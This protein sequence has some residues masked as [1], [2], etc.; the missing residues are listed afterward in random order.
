[1]LSRSFSSASSTDKASVESSGFGYSRIFSRELMAIFT[2]S[3]RAISSRR[4][5]QPAFF[6]SVFDISRLSGYKQVIRSYAR[7][8]VAVMGDYLVCCDMLPSLKEKLKSA[9]RVS[10]SFPIRA[11][12][13]FAVASSR[14]LCGPYPAG[15]CFRDMRIEAISDVPLGPRHASNISLELKYYSIKPQ[16]YV[17]V[18]A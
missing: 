17:R 15:L 13:E 10:D 5:P 1:M 12:I 4:N 8:I 6:A 11:I 7:R 18:R 2:V 9:G 16:V 14:F 3:P